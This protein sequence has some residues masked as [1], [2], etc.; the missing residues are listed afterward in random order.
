[1]VI[2]AI[3]TAASTGTIGDGKIFVTTLADGIR[4][5]TRE[6]GDIAL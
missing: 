6:S 4:I 2:D 5:R 3:L 1:K